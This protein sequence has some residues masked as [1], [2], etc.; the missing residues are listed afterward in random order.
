[1]SKTKALSE[2]C[3]QQ[4]FAKGFVLNSGLSFGLFRFKLRIRLRSF[5]SGHDLD[6]TLFFAS[7]PLASSSWLCRWTLS[8]SISNHLRS[9]LRCCC[10]P[11][12]TPSPC[13]ML[14]ILAVLW[15]RASL[16]HFR[17]GA[18]LTKLRNKNKP[19]LKRSQTTDESSLLG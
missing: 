14:R 9:L 11:A 12:S 3:E 18:F 1:M 6:L 10:S 8:F 13:S 4:C 5:A 16:G 15:G 19:L 2:R 17:F 7:H